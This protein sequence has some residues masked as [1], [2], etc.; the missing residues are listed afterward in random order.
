[1]FLS[2]TFAAGWLC[3]GTGAGAGAGAFWACDTLAQYSVAKL[4][5]A[6][7]AHPTVYCNI[8]VLKESS[9]HKADK[10]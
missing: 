4:M 8:S 7:R 2:S 10:L 1:M 9:I 3:A 5:H 6:R